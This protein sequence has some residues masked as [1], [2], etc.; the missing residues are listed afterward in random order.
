MAP[1]SLRSAP[2]VC[3]P[4]LATEGQGYQYDA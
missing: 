2:P 1:Q 3:G 4:V